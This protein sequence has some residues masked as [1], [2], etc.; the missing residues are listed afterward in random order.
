MALFQIVVEGDHSV[1]WFHN[2]AMRGL[3]VSVPFNIANGIYVTGV[4]LD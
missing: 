3:A 1:V 4:L 2:W